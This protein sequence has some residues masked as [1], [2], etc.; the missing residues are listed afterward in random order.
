[1]KRN[2][3]RGGPSMDPGGFIAIPW[4]VVDAPAYQS[5]SMH[6]RGLLLELGRQLRAHNNGALL[7]SRN[8]L[9]PRGWKSA[10]M[11]TKAKRELIA[12]G[13]IHE[14][15]HGQRPNKASWYAVTWRPLDKLDGLDA[16]AAATFMRGAYKALPIAA[17]KPTRD[18][19]YRKWDRKTSPAKTHPLDRPTV[20]ETPA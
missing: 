17:P 12:A 3:K 19:L 10:D 14:T 2:D 18:E 9:G 7:C 20:Q 13:F 5:L 11:I 1:M 6:A 4:S 8:Y 15:V 16:G